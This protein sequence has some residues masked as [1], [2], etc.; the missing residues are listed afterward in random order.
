MVA[1]N[2]ADKLID[3]DSSST[4]IVD[5]LNLAATTDHIMVIPV[6]GRNNTYLVFKV[7]REA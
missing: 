3:P 7:E 4:L 1:F 2:F 5:A 6:S